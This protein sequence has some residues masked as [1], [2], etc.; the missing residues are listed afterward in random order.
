M[1]NVIDTSKILITGNV[2]LL[3]LIYM[4]T[5]EEYVGKLVKREV[6]KFHLTLVPVAIILIYQLYILKLSFVLSFIQILFI[7]W[8]FV[9]AITINRLYLY[10]LAVISV[11]FTPVLYFFGIQELAI[12]LATMG[13][14]S[15]VT[16]VFKD[17]FYEK[18]FKE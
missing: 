10:W 5:M 18:L 1:I 11:V 12:F 13:F 15:L 9:Y 4:Y 8:V 2:L 7:V 6:T 3:L 14:F 16:G 17:L